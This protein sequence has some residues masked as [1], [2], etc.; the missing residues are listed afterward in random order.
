MKAIIGKNPFKR[1]TM[2]VIGSATDTAAKLVQRDFESE[3]RS[4]KNKPQFSIEKDGDDVRRVVTD[5]PIFLYQDLG[6]KPHTIRPRNK[7]ALFWKGAGHPV[8]VV[9]HPGTKPQH[10]TKRVQAKA[11]SRILDAMNDAMRKAMN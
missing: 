4:W 1:I 3:V 5:D 10:F 7:R 6:T 2:A 8:K 9:R 11:A